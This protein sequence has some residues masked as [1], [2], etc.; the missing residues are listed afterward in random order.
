MRSARCMPACD[1]HRQ[2]RYVDCTMAVCSR[3]RATN[4]YR[5]EPHI[6]IPQK[7]RSAQQQLDVAVTMAALGPPRRSQRGYV[8]DPS[9][10]LQE[11]RMIEDTL[12]G[13][14][15]RP[16]ASTALAGSPASAE[17]ARITG[18]SHLDN[19]SGP[20][21]EIMAASSFEG[22]T[23]INPQGETLGEIEEIML[24]VRSGRIVRGPVGGR[25]SRHRREVLCRAVAGLHDGHRSESLHSRC[26]QGAPV[27]R[28][29]FRQGPLA[30]H[31]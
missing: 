21:P 26:R 9:I 7:R 13:T 18:S 16:A 5:Q 3:Q 22:E 17:G 11:T 20:G 23:V 25:L 24:D 10:T 6:R 14:L 15:S 31:G 2:T 28:A 4:R 12:T 27:E 1:R 30:C 8:A 29:R 19:H